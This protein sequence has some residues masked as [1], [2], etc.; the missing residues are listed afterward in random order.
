M[1]GP[2]SCQ[3]EKPKAKYPPSKRDAAALS[4][5]SNSLLIILKT[6][7]GFLTG[8][9]SI[10]AE[11]IHS[12]LDLVAAVIAF[13]AVRL[14]DKPPDKTHPFG[15]GKLE[16]LSGSVEALLIFVAAGFIISEAVK[17]LSTGTE[18]EFLN[19]GI[20]VM[21]V[22]MVVNILVS[23]RLLKVAHATDSIAL[24]ADARHL[25]TD[26][27]TSAGVLV[28]L[29]VVQLTGLEELDAIIAL[30]VALLIIKAAWEV[31]VKSV[32]GLLDTRLPDEE[33]AE[34]AAIIKDE[35]QDL[36]GF[37]SLRTRK[38][39]SWRFAD[40]HVEAPRELTVEEAHQICD[41]LEKKLEEKTLTT[42]DVK[43]LQQY[44]I[45]SSLYSKIRNITFKELKLKALSKK[46]KTLL[47]KKYKELE[48]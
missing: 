44:G 47:D 11:A 40:L 36:V 45:D 2:N 26:V 33:E 13:I 16:N 17:R 22:S 43:I 38:S 32:S 14:S 42:E 25:T 12:L 10:L 1:S 3:Y 34:I 18:L 6:T 23:R 24:E 21:T 9:V 15:H 28:G 48:T 19:V 27:L 37:H 31:L 41:R 30:L 8:S 35:T 46:N 5:V 7:V 39:G 4:V 20:A 29:L